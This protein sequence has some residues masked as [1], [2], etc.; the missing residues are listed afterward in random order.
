[1][2]KSYIDNAFQNIA[3]QGGRNQTSSAAGASSSP[4]Q[5]TL[6]HWT[7]QFSF[8]PT[9]MSY[10]FRSVTFFSFVCVSLFKHLLWSCTMLEHK[11]CTCQSLTNLFSFCCSMC[12]LRWVCGGW[13]SKVL[14]NKFCLEQTA[15]LSI[16]ISSSMHVLVEYTG[17]CPNQSYN[18]KYQWQI[19]VSVPL[20]S[21]CVFFFQFYFSMN[22]FKAEV[23]V[24]I[25]A[26]FLD[27][28]VFVF[29][30]ALNLKTTSFTA[31]TT[32][33]KGDGLTC[34]KSEVMI[35]VHVA[36]SYL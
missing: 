9:T 16:C 13:V 31:D 1:M 21:I 35:N 3:E 18:T 22:Y 26:W 28:A 6:N 29:C 5:P 19:F 11:G 30:W 10:F 27:H 32:H 23:T 24:I 7:L 20:F 36:T 17:Q 34:G 12:A 33:H 15:V 14:S 2:Y 4:T 8:L 25:P